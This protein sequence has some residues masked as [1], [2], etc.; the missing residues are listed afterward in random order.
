MLLIIPLQEMVMAYLY[1]TLLSY[2]K[3]NA[4]APGQGHLLFPTVGNRDRREKAG[5]RN[6][7]NHGG[8]DTQD[9]RGLGR[10]NREPAA[11]KT[12]F[13]QS[14]RCAGDR[15]T[16]IRAGWDECTVMEEVGKAG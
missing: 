12:P 9:E 16:T 2:R 7:G 10:Y 3:V 5:E 13:A 15:P 6:H 14:D 11:M 1:H 4:D 8:R